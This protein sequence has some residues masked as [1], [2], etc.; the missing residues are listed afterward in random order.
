V[1]KRTLLLLFYRFYPK[2]LPPQYNQWNAQPA[3]SIFPGGTP[4]DL[5]HANQVDINE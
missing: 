5:T 3:F 4:S 2:N 1:Q